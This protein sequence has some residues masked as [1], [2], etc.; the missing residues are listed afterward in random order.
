MNTKKIVSVR[1]QIII[2]SLDCYCETPLIVYNFSNNK[3]LSATI[4]I[5]KWYSNYKILI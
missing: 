1:R 5:F 4:S 2:K 3:I